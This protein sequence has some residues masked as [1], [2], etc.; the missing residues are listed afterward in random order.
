MIIFT[1]VQQNRSRWFGSVL[2]RDKNDW[3]NKCIDY[4]VEGL[5]P[6]YRPK[7]TW[8]EVVRL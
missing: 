4:E 3:M 6:R 1:V 8:S 7:K 5:G 2:T